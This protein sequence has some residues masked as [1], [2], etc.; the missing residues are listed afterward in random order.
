MWLNE[1][2]IRIWKAGEIAPAGTYVR[3]D[4]RSYH[5]I[6]LEQEGPLPASFDG[7]VALYRPAPRQARGRGQANER[8]S[9][10][11]CGGRAVIPGRHDFSPSPLP[12]PMSHCSCPSDQVAARYGHAAQGVW[13]RS[14]LY[15]L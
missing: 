12:H 11:A 4:N 10:P 8:G 14:W 5:L 7:Q 1:S 15:H 9:W 13:R 3:I 2:E 6:A